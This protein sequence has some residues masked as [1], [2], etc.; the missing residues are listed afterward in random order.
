MTIDNNRL[1]GDFIEINADISNQQHNSKL[2]KFISKHRA[3]RYRKRLIKSA[4]NIATSK[5]ILNRDNLYEF[6][7]Y[8]YNNFKNGAF[9]SV[10]QVKAD[11]N[12]SKIQAV[13]KFDIYY[14]IIYIEKDKEVFDIDIKDRGA[15][16][17]KSCSVTVNELTSRNPKTSDLLKEVNAELL[18][19]ISEYILQN[20]IIYL[21]NDN[22]KGGESNVEKEEE[23]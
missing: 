16:D 8:C 20:T 18:E 3:N 10:F 4:K 14:V 21:D 23:T 13:L 9:R 19:N 12:Y 1:I 15:D 2:P 17:R 22:F 7:I 11:S 5:M 6:F